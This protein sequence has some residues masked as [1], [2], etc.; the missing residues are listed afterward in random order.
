MLHPYF[1]G[2]RVLPGNGILHIPKIAFN[3]GNATLG[4]GGAM[5]TT[6][7]IEGC[8]DEHTEHLSAVY[9]LRHKIFCA[10]KGWVPTN[11]SKQDVD[12]YDRMNPVHFVHLD[13]AGE[14]DGCCRIVPTTGPNMLRDIFPELMGV[15]PIPCA[16]AIWE[17]SRFAVDTER[18]DDSYTMISDVTSELLITLFTYALEK[19]MS[20]IVA[21]TD[22]AFE[23]VL[24]RA[25]LY[26]TRY[27]PPRKYSN[28]EA[29]AGYAVVSEETIRQLKERRDKNLS[30]HFLPYE[31]EIIPSNRLDIHRVSHPPQEM[32]RH[33]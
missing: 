31:Q 20:R 33:A 16:K 17:I 19:N 8:L 3:N 23:R 1:Y 30:R 7:A 25:G 10:Q 24:R 2:F 32:G 4:L 6:L 22:T 18:L 12:I 28:C 14:V 9:A 27:A 26:T 11:E 15:Q 29:V 5:G 13:D 21:V